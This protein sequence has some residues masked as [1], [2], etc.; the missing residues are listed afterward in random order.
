[1]SNIASSLFSVK[2]LNCGFIPDVPRW[3]YQKASIPTWRFYW[4]P[5]PG[6]WVSSHAEDIALTPDVAVLIP[7]QTPFA[8][9]SE[10]VFAHFY[11]H[12]SLPDIASARRLIWKLPA[13]KILAPCITGN[14]GA[15][16]FRQLNMAAAAAVNSALLMLPESALCQE[17]A[18]AGNDV[19]NKAMQIV[20]N[21]PGFSCS[22][23]ELAKLC[24]S[25]VNTLQRQ[26]L[27]ATGVTV[28][29]WILNRK[30][31]YAAQL[32]IYR[33]SSIKEC[34]D[35]LGFADRY[36]FSKVFKLYFGITPAQFVRSGGI[37]L[38]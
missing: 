28:K 38:P 7:P 37:P 32:L 12:F 36:H 20:E 21:D 13:Q 4:N 34:A 17:A 1:M 25:S 27:K 11:V 35:Q 6:A 10:R 8:T 2:I 16:T 5:E 19:F 29:K 18:P 26:F 3:Q 23:E 9:R 14:P 22:C 24:Q 30:M 15:L 31:E 33:G